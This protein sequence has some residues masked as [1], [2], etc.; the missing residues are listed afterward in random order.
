MICPANPLHA[1]ITIFVFLLAV[2]PVAASGGLVAFVEVPALRDAISAEQLGQIRASIAEYEEKR[3]VLKEEEAPFLLPFFPQGGVLGRDLFV[4]NYTDQDPA[5]GQVQDWDCSDY[6][7]DGHRGH[8]SLIRSFREQAIGVPVFAALDGVVVDAHDGEPDMNIEWIEGTEANYVVID[9]GGG[10]FGL[11]FHLRQG[12]VAVVPGQVVAAGTQLGL[13]GS[14]GISNWPHLH[15]ETWKDRQWFEPSAGPCRAG[16]SFWVSQ[17]PVSRDFYVADFSMSRGPIASTDRASRV[18]DLM[19]RTATFVKGRQTV[20]QRLYLRNLPESSTYRL[21]VLNPRRQVAYEAGGGSDDPFLRVAFGFF[22]FEI[23]LDT[24]G[25]WRYQLEING[26]LAVDVPFRVV[27]SERQRT[28][29][30]PNAVRT[31]LT[32][33]KPVEGQVMTCEVQTSLITED[34]DFDVVGYRYEWKVNNRVVRSVTSAALADLLPADAAQPK[35]KVSCRVVV[36][37]RP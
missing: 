7:Y 30:R 33:T 26:S 23:N 14:S 15:F 1:G 22:E 4:S 2:S 6:T 18:Y 13:T 12:S 10:Y 31:R 3:G 37:D 9:H 25:T 11:Y 8:D 19:E 29:R 24:L 28:N 27:A 16:D 21:R 35:D 36:T 34:P 5:R 32:P 17:P 20:S